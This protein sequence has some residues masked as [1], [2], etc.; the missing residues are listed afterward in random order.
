ML[1]VKNITV[2]YDSVQALRSVS[3]NVSKGSIVSL[4]GNNGAGKSTTLKAISGVVPLS[5]GE[6]WFEGERIDRLTIPAIVRLGITQ[7]PEGKRLFQFMTVYEN[8]KMGAALRS[9][10]KDLEPDFEYVYTLFPVLRGKRKQEAGSLSGGEQQMLTIAR[11][12]MARPRLL[13]LDEPSLGL[14]PIVVELLAETI[15]RINQ[16]GVTVILV[17]QNASM[18]IELA[19]YAYVLETGQIAIEGEKEKLRDNPHVKKAYLSM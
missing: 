6:I 11:G 17:E 7:V 13:L 19:H 10:D 4:L 8:L 12:L 2:K 3:F 5:G 14:A 18:A 1:D 16:Q 9:W 15:R